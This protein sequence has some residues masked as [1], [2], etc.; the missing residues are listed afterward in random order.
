MI[1]KIENWIYT[2]IN[3]FL[4][5]EVEGYEKEQANRSALAVIGMAGRFPGA[6]SVS[7]FWDN[8]VAGKDCV[9]L[10]DEDRWNGDFFYSH[11]IDRVGKTYSNAGGFIADADKFDAPFF[12]VSNVEAPYIDPQQRLLLETSWHALEDAGVNPSVIKGERTGVF[13]GLSSW[14]YFFRFQR[15]PLEEISGYIPT[16]SSLA[17]AAGRLAYFYGFEG[18]TVTVDTSCSSSLTALHAAR[19]SLMLNE[20]DIALVG[21]ASLV[22]SPRTA[23]A[24]SQAK[25][26]SPTGRCRAFSADADGFVRGEGGGVL[27]IK[28]LEA[29]LKDGDRIH[30]CILGSAINQDGA[31]FGLTVPNGKAQ[32]RVIETALRD[33]GVD[34]SEISYVEAH[35]TGTR[36]GD[37]IEIG[38][39]KRIF[40]DRQQGPLFVGSV[41]S[42]IGHLEAAA[43]M[44]G[45]CKAIQAVKH[46]RIP[47]SLHLGEPNP[48]VDWSDGLLQVPTETVAWPKGT[49]RRIAG[50]SSFGFSGTNAHVVIANAPLQA[51]GQE[52]EALGKSHLLCLSAKTDAALK[53]LMVAHRQRLSKLEENQE[54][55]RDYCVS[56]LRGRAALNHRAWAVGA[57]A[58]ALA[59]AL[60][61]L[62]E[63][64]VLSPVAGQSVAARNKQHRIVFLCPGQGSAY[65][66]MGRQLYE[67]SSL[68]RETFDHY[69]AIFKAEIGVNVTAVAHDGN[70]VIDDTLLA[71]PALFCLQLALASYW[72]E[73]GIRPKGIVGH[74]LG[75]ITGA[76][77][78]GLLDPEEAAKFVAQR[79]RAMQDLCATGAMAS[80]F[81][82]LEEVQSTI[83]DRPVDVAA[84]NG[85][86]KY[87]ISGTPS[88]I[89]DIIRDCEERGLA[90]A[91]LGVNRAFHSRLMDP[92]LGAIGAAA[93][94]LLPSQSDVTVF[95][96]L[97]GRA[98]TVDDLRDGSY[99]VRQV[100]EPVQF[101][102]CLEALPKSGKYVFLE[103][104]PHSVLS[105]LV[106]AHFLSDQAEVVASLD[107]NRPDIDVLLAA[108]GRLFAS[109][110]MAPYQL[111]GTAGVTH[112][113]LP[114]YPFEPERHWVNDPEL[115][116]EPER[117]QSTSGAKSYC[118]QLVHEDLP[119]DAEQPAS[120]TI[121]LLSLKGINTH[122]LRTAYERRGAEVREFELG[123]GISDQMLA[124]MPEGG[125][126]AMVVYLPS[127][128]GG[129]LALGCVNIEKDFAHFSAHVVNMAALVSSLQEHPQLMPRQA[130]AIVSCA[131]SAKGET[132][133]EGPWCNGIWSAVKSARLETG[134]SELFFVGGQGSVDTLAS[135]LVHQQGQDVVTDIFL[136]GDRVTGISLAT[137]DPA[138]PG[139]DGP[140]DTPDVAVVTGALGSIGRSLIDW[141]IDRG[142][143]HF[144]LSGRNLG[145]VSAQS[146]IKQWTDRGAEVTCVEGGLEQPII[147]AEIAEKAT[148]SGRKVGIFHCAGV[149]Q[150][151]QLKSIDEASLIDVCH[152][153]IHGTLNLLDAFTGRQPEVFVGFSSIAAMI[154]SPGQTNYAAANGVMDAI[155]QRK[156]A[157]GW[158]CVSINW[159]P[160]ADTRMVGLA[161]SDVAKRFNAIGLHSLAPDTALAA[162][163]DVLAT[164]RTQAAVL[165]ADWSL[166]VRSGADVHSADFLKHV[167]QDASPRKIHRQSRQLS[168]LAHDARDERKN[169]RGFVD[170]YIQALIRHVGR[171]DAGVELDMALNLVE[172]GFDSLLVQQMKIRLE[173][174]LRLSLPMRLFAE[175]LSI[176]ELVSDVSMRLSIAQMSG[177]SALSREVVEVI[178][179]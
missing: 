69:A 89:G 110:D 157:E 156:A 66:S 7:E 42:N 164:G 15:V 6:W 58:A 123:A 140:I 170:Q 8:L 2:R 167:C 4:G 177:P 70:G 43:G 67:R 68:Y 48:A 47:A 133:R 142:H 76:A 178:R 138:E 91:L 161:G 41:K 163:Q 171:M 55:C 176:E 115:A 36:L 125:F 101:R 172:I 85:D 65:R 11:E 160:W 37:P 12:N 86:G 124:G 159:G 80:V 18:P 145:T 88:D 174:D 14:E 60:K 112:A 24:Y 144:I 39:L 168:K 35:G 19:Q 136:D 81:A 122:D 61:G 151:V 75:E 95:S 131:V 96:N 109:G 102:A 179:I 105:G 90:A 111:L 72:R 49:E 23:I 92:A 25:M 108:K 103:I 56:A 26:L 20:V 94:H 46:A 120:G 147:C 117:R 173:R 28:R 169:R 127:K 87:T 33:A 38:A 57:D 148:E 50:V 44:A 52:P 82:P 84:H 27:V 175:G 116:E 21:S 83:A 165:D 32:T 1:H 74:S 40:G 62:E 162:M 99:W 158:Q 13:I 152:P 155:L 54:A 149:L 118:Y 106:R 59:L 29:A 154:G 135:A 31:S 93:A 139:Q 166:F 9:T 78:A 146:I 77:I 130:I 141:M 63:G 17:V 137:I 97:F 22:F 10:V 51:R 34:A 53:R 129:G 64:K 126:S 128:V 79:A 143:R 100:R 107:K 132:L 121:A 104:G 5:G 71:Q 153:K 150:D 134:L 3:L 73:Q 114:L 98:L 30:A 119:V 16:G 45:I 113:D